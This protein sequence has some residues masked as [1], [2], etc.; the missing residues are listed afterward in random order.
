MVGTSLNTTV[1]RGY[2]N[3]SDLARISEPDVFDQNLNPEGTQRDLKPWHAREAHAYA[4]GNVKRETKNRLW[5]EVILNVRD[6]NVVSLGKPQNCLT[7]MTVDEGK[8]K[9]TDGMNPQISRVDG[10]HRLYWGQGLVEKGIVKLES[11]DVIVPFCITVGLSR[12]EEAALFRDI[13]ANQVKMDT[14]HLDHLSYVLLGKDK[15]QTSELALWMAMELH[16][17]QDSPFYNS[18][19]LG[20][21]KTKGAKYLFSLRAFKEGIEI[22]LKNSTELSSDKVPFDLQEKAISNYWNAVKMVFSEEWKNF[23]TNLLLAYFTYF[24]WSKLGAIVIDTSFRKEDPTVEGMKSQLEG[25]KGNVDWGKDGT[26]KGFGGKGGGD[27]AFQVLK[28]FLPVEYELE[29]SLKKLKG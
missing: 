22:L 18:I 29:K 6:G 5:P 16:Q 23:N 25:I 13:N 4:L 12:M 15:I 9:K 3:A 14:S 21:R 28:K 20:G 19:Y 27:K 24:A 17:R 8:I 2:A 1:Y 26:F 11:L 10:N 7:K